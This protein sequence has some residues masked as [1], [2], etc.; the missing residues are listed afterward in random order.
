MIYL[1]A[2]DIADN[3]RRAGIASKLEQ[4]GIRIQKS[5]FRCDISAELAETLKSALVRLLDEK[6][7]SLYIVPL[8]EKDLEKA[9]WFGPQIRREY[10]SGAY[11]I[12]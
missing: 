1:Y 4:F 10:A 7:D 6:E 2:Y 3:H 9:E 12:L 5:I 8:C 11:S